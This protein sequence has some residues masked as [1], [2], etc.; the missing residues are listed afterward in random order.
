MHF[1]F[2][3]SHSQEKKKMNQGLQVTLTR[4]TVPLEVPPEKKTLLTLDFKRTWLVKLYATETVD[5]CNELHCFWSY[6]PLRIEGKGSNQEKKAFGKT[7][8]WREISQPRVKTHLTS[9]SRRGNLFHTFWGK[10]GQ[11]HIS[12]KYQFE[13]FIISG[14]FFVNWIEGLWEIT[15][16]AA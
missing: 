4:N 12:M 2:Y 16:N 7:M 10:P 9:S 3:L 15:R 13:R 14:N 5:I 11:R 6:S 8:A 1:F